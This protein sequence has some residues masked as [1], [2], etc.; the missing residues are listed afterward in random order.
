MFLYWKLTNSELEERLSQNRCFSI[1]ILL[2]TD[3]F[4]A[5]GTTEPESMR[6]NRNSIQNHPF[7]A[8]GLK[9]TRINTF[10]LKFYWKWT[11]YH[12]AGIVA[13]VSIC[14]QTFLRS[15]YHKLVFVIGRPRWASKPSSSLSEVCLSRSPN[16]DKQPWLSIQAPFFCLYLVLHLPAV[17]L[18]QIHICDRQTSVLRRASFKF[19]Y[20][21]ST[22]Y[23]R[24]PNII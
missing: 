21:D 17:C 16:Q 13:S 20:A 6:F 2:K 24:T 7:W 3:Q 14:P 9:W 10:Q 12:R 15:A 11:T 4:S 23:G 18:S 19:P 5:G 22:P 1:E 8:G